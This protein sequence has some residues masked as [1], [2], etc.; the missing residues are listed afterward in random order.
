M[1]INIPSEIIYEIYL[2]CQT[3]KLGF[4]QSGNTKGGSIT[5]LLTGL[6]LAAMTTDIFCFYLQNRLNQTSQ[7]GTVIL[8][9]LAFPG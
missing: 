4:V 8:H 3:V 5:V 7:T 2:K 9:P 1:T 6:E